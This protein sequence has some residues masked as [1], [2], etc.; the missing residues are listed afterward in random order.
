MN[1]IA[2]T[3]KMDL[4]KYWGRRVYWASVGKYS[5]FCYT[6]ISQQKLLRGFYTFV[7]N[8]WV[9]VLLESIMICINILFLKFLKHLVFVY[10]RAPHDVKQNTSVIYTIKKELKVCSGNK[11]HKTER[12]SE[13]RFY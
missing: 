4:G 10:V 13:A 7:T 3:L 9:L 5:R 12:K 8:I 11:K 6:D 2:F 1:Q